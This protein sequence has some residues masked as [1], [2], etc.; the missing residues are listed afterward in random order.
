MSTERT[1]SIWQVSI[2][3]TDGRFDLP[4]ALLSC[5]LRKWAR[6]TPPDHETLDRQLRLRVRQVGDAAGGDVYEPL[7]DGEAIVASAARQ[8]QWPH[9]ISAEVH[10]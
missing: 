10:T 9:K 1:I 7:N 5:A 2:K 3:A 8:A 6:S 4:I